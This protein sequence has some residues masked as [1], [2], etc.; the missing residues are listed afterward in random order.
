MK[1]PLWARVISAVGHPLL[2]P[3]YTLLTLF[4]LNEYLQAHPTSFLY[5]GFI[6][7]VNTFGASISLYL[8]FRRGFIGDLEIRERAQ[9]TW[10]FTLVLAYYSMTLYLV[11]SDRSVHT[12]PEF[13]GMLLGVV[14]SI[15]GGIVAT[16]WFKLSM[17]TMAAGGVVGAVFALGQIQFT[18]HFPFL[19]FWIVA[20]GLIGASR[21][22]LRAHTPPQVY[23][24]F[25]W[26][27]LCMYA[28]VLLTA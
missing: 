22:A 15:A 17:H 11:A 25:L 16:R 24:G 10:P 2:M 13:V 5:F 28:C 14:V 21:L 26:G 18:S 4:A 27:A 19:V 7:L 23:A 3:L 9:R 6:L 12:P 8:L 20:A 1:G